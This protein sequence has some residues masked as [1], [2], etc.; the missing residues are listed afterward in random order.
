MTEPF[1]MWQNAADSL[2]KGLALVNPDGFVMFTNRTWIRLAYLHGLSPLWDRPGLNL[3]SHFTNE[4]CTNDPVKQDMLQGITSILSGSL[5]YYSIE[6]CLELQGNVWYLMEASPL[7]IKETGSNHGLLLL[8]SDITAYKVCES[9][10][11]GTASHHCRLHGL[12][13]ICAVCKKIKDEAENWNSIEEYLRKH[14][15]AEFTHDIC[16]DCIRLLYPQYSSIL[17]TP[18]KQGG[19]C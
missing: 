12:L 7:M 3:I 18:D 9:R 14:A 10:M 6:L 13:P 1:T 4:A 17:D 11:R 15:Q 16:P 5:D 19:G 2:P 8:F